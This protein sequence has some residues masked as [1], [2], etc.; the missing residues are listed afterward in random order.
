MPQF[1]AL[2]RTPF[3]GPWRRFTRPSAL[4]T[5]RRADAVRACLDDAEAAA[6]AGSYV[7]GFVCYEAA[8]AFGLPAQAASDALLPLCCFAAFPADQVDRLDAITASG[9]PVSGWTPSIDRGRYLDAIRRI[10]A[11]I[12]DGDT[13]QLNFTFRLRAPF[14]GDAGRLFGDLVAAQQGPWSAFIDLGSAA[15]CSASPEL[16]FTL[17]DGRLECRPMKG[18]APRGL[19]S[20]ADRAAADALHQSAKNRSENVMI[21]DLVR[22]DLGRVAVTGSVDV[23]SLFDVEQYPQQ[24]QMTS[25]IAADAGEASI[26]DIFAALFPSGS[27]TGAPKHRS[28]E[29]LG[30]LEDSPRGIYTGAIGLIAPGGRAH[31]NVAIRTVVIDRS[32]ARAEFGVGSGV[33]WE[34]SDRDEYEE[35]RVKAAILTKRLPP[36]DLLETLAWTPGRGYV[37]L[38]RHLAR[39]GASAGY[40]GWAYDPDEVRASL[41]SAVAA[42]TTPARVRLLVDSA[43]RSRCETADLPPCVPRW[44]AALAAVPI[45]VDDVL[46]YHKTTQRETYTTARASRPDADTVLLWNGRGEVTESPE[47]NLIAEFAG[48]RVTPPVE[49]GLLPG[50]LRAELLAAKLVSE[51]RILSGDLPRAERLWLVN[52]VR[53]WI[54]V[55]LMK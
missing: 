48:R 52:S 25:T 50:T 24:W 47:A 29:I 44:T 10:K 14:A 39:L 1:E 49:S 27:V 51:E 15:I 38:E 8:A 16:F 19:S 6:R 43:G 54:P 28:M 26:A 3:A 18:T 2:I 53:G 46:L 4:F 12:A 45:D 9:E 23:R 33:V 36:F 40:F 20:S 22:N 11:L 34:S 37:L 17:E 30:T 35:C 7:V 5:A 41:A 31:F 42:R 21:V 32:A 13:Y 55:D